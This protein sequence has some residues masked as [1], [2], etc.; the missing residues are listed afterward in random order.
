ML[1][2]CVVTLLYQLNRNLQVVRTT[3]NSNSQ[4][5]ASLSF[6]LSCVDCEQ[7]LIMI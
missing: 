1:Q 5:Q 3:Y 2:K 6:R 7:Y 4:L